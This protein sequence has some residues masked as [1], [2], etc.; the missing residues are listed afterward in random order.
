MTKINAEQMARAWDQASLEYDEYFTPRFAPYLGTA[1]GALAARQMELPPGPIVVPC[2]GPG[3]ELPGL[4]R[5]FEGRQVLASDLSKVMVERARARATQLSNVVVE[6]RDATSLG[7]PAAGAAGLFSAF[8]LQLLPDP[9]LALGHW[10]ELLAAGG[11]LS[12]VY[13]P[14][15]SEPGSPFHVLRELLVRGNVSRADWEQALPESIRA[16]GGRVRLDA[17]VAF[18]MQHDDA[19]SLWRGFSHLGSLRAMAAAR[20]EAAVAELGA[21]FVQ[22]LPPGPLVHTPEARLLLIERE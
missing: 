7:L 1:L 19:Q 11:A 22:R 15:H 20:G 21:E 2:V 16:G 17:R 10:L 14:E 18:E 4:S 9:A 13:W 8:G 12:I 3:H 5:V 6:Q